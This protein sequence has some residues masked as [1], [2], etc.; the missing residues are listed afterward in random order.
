MD[1]DRLAERAALAE[2][3][4]SYFRYL[5][6]K[7][8]SSWRE[9]FTDDMVFYNESAPVP[10]GSDP[11][12]TS[13]DDFV[14]MVSRRLENSVTVHQGHM[15]ELRLIDDGHAEGVW[16]MFDWVDSSGSGGTSMQGFGHYHEQYVKGTDGKWRIRELRITRLRTD[17]TAG[18]GAVPPK[19]EPWKRPLSPS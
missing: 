8:W 6:T 17:L 9:L 12:T 11:M 3:K 1:D 5:D 14:E 16:A 18:T 10:T 15:P 7:R 19:V 13:G 4:A 2:L